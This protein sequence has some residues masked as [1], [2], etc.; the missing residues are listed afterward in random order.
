ML[1]VSSKGMELHL[2]IDKDSI[3]NVL[4]ILPDMIGLNIL[5]MPALR[6][7]I[8]CCQDKNIRIIGFNNCSEIFTDE[9]LPNLFLIDNKNIID[10]MSAYFKIHETFD[11]VFDFLS[12][13]E[14][15]KIL[16]DSGMSYRVGWDYPESNLYN[17]PVKFPTHD[18][19]TIYDYLEYLAAIGKEYSYGTPQLK[20]KDETRDQGKKWLKENGLLSERL[21]IFGVGGGNNKKRWPLENYFKLRNELMRHK[22]TDTLFIIGPNELELSDEIRKNDIKAFIACNLPLQT[23]KGI[24]SHAF[25]TISND[26]AVMHM[27]AALGISTI[28]VFLASDP[29]QWFP[30]Q[31]PSIYVIGKELACRPCYREDCADWQCNDPSLLG[32][33]MNGFKTIWA[34]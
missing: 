30:Y 12:S 24:L 32:K 34:T 31:R 33:V 25:C 27:S 20:S 11:I 29:I 9:N 3:R 10:E 4:I 28:G 7:I 5:C 2:R 15:G 17:V 26:Y 23:L 21:I 14:S 22:G 19:S 6:Q 1:D 13:R 16:I 18:R 8:N